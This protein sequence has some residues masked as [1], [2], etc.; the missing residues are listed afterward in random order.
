MEV[1][2]GKEYEIFYKNIHNGGGR[3]FLAVRLPEQ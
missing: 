3:P 2:G 1:I